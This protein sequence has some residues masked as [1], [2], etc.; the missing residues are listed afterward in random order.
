MASLCNSGH[1]FRQRAAV[2]SDNAAKICDTV[3]NIHRLAIAETNCGA[4]IH[5]EQFA[6]AI[7]Q[8]KPNPRTMCFQT[9]E[10]MLQLLCSAGK[11]QRVIRVARAVKP[12][13][14]V[15]RKE[16]TLHIMKN[17]A[18]DKEEEVRREWATLPAPRMR[19][20]LWTV[21]A[22]LRDKEPG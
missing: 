20:L 9:V 18:V 1:N 14:I 11:Q 8:A 13:R 4:S 3:D 21:A 2:I 15:N 6:L 22:S 19:L 10:K 17:A 12:W 7:V 5:A 16:V